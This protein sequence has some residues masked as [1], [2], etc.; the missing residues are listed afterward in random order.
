MKP[1]KHFRSYFILLVT[2]FLSS[3]ED[4]VVKQIAVITIEKDMSF[5]SMGDIKSIS[6]PTEK[7]GYVGSDTNFILKTINGGN[8]WKEIHFE[9]YGDCNAIEFQDKDNGMVLMGGTVYVTHDGGYFW[10]SKTTGDF[11][12]ITD[13]GLWVVGED[14][15]SEFEVKTSNNSGSFFTSYTKWYVNY[16]FSSG[17]VVDSKVIVFK[18]ESSGDLITGVDLI[19]GKSFYLNSE[20][21][22]FSEA[23]HDA[24]IYNSSSVLIGLEGLLMSSGNSYN[25]YSKSYLHLYNYY[26][27][28]GFEDRSMCVG[29]ST[30][31]SNFNRDN[32]EEWQEVFDSNGN[33]FKTTF[34]KVKF[35]DRE[36]IYLGGKDG[37]LYKAK[38]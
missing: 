25:Y 10:S 24:Y 9:G 34:Y 12:G 2:L 29:D 16:G 33:G 3:C 37:L 20:E 21:L 31:S 17:K 14:H 1:I 23:I 18:D 7:V 8:S 27:I 15:G 19:T 6:F 36:T 28:D 13:E 11:I 30:I 4:E 35:T 5:N 32:G 38:I 22:I 26:S